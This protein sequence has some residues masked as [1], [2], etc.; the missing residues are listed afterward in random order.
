M[1]VPT[2]PIR[3]LAGL[4]VVAVLAGCATGASVTSS[5]PT[6]AA[7][8]T[9]KPGGSPAA[10]EPSTSASVSTSRHLAGI[11]T[12]IAGQAGASGTT[13]GQGV[14]ARF[15]G[16]GGLAVDSTGNLYVAD[17]LNN[18]IRKIAPNGTVSTLAGSPQVSGAEDGRGTAASFDKPSGIAVDTAGNVYTADANAGT[19]RRIAP[20]G[21]VTTIAGNAYDRGFADGQ[22]ATAKFSS[23]NGPSVDSAGNVYVADWDANVIRKIAPDGTVATLAGKPGVSGLADGKGSAALFF[24]PHVTALDSVG[25]L[26]VSDT[27]NNAVRKVSP[28]GTVSTVAGPTQGKPGST[29]TLSEPVGLAVDPTGDLYVANFTGNTVVRISPDGVVSLL[30]GTSGTVGTAD[31]TG[32]AAL[33]EIPTGVAL[34]GQGTLYVADGQ[35]GTI[36][37]IK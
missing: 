35:A 14:A 31:G 36:R 9:A 3:A 10:V 8:A 6:P 4:A 16:P 20:D 26:F 23:P 27:G 30:A 25:N 34:D 29:A 17:V 15:N 1:A 33:F 19:I 18:T 28:D 13:D 2:P 22:G 7:T 32:P 24:N 21:T 5:P 11:V 12:T 37:K